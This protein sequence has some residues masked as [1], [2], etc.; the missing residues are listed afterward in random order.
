ME[1]SIR[2]LVSCL[3]VAFAFALP[4]NQA[5]AHFIS[6][7][8]NHNYFGSN[9]EKN[10]DGFDWNKEFDWK[11]GFNFQKD[12]EWKNGFDG[13]CENERD[14]GDYKEHYCSC[15]G[16]KCDNDHNVPEPTPLALLGL[17][18]GVIGLVRRFVPSRRS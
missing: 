6:G 10:F 13:Y 9:F 12:S 5:Q 7:G 1:L 11:D 17:G 14:C 15:D 8:Y 3:L 16:D 18:L 4:V 2:S